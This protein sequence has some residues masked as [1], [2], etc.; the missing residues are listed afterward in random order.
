M[1]LS[2]VHFPDFEAFCRL[3]LEGDLVPVYRRLVSDTLTPVGPSTRSMP[4]GAP[5]CLKA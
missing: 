2:P 4:A 1:P 3:A 5:A